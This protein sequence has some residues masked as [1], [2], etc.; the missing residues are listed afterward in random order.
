MIEKVIVFDPAMRHAKDVENEINTALA[1]GWS[2]ASVYDEGN[3]TMILLEGSFEGLS[4][5]EQ[6]ER[7]ELMRKVN[8]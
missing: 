3:L 2:L 7:T 1:S 6:L 5:A 8:A 4:D